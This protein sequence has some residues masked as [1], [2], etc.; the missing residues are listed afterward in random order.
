MSFR[1]LRSLVMMV[2]LRTSISRPIYNYNMFH[3]KLISHYITNEGIEISCIYVLL[4]GRHLYDNGYKNYDY[5]YYDYG[6]IRSS[7]A[8]QRQIQ[9][10][11]FSDLTIAERVGIFS[12]VTYERYIL[13][14][15][16]CL[17]P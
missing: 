16:R 10:D 15:F 14:I 3:S 6:D 12:F 5:D 17:E 13:F 9:I 2:I 1:W 4:T 8:S 11:T 7:A